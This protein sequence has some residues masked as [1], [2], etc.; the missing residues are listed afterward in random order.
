MRPLLTRLHALLS[1]HKFSSLSTGII[2][3]MCAGLLLPA[4][5]GGLVLTGLRQEQIDKEAQSHI[6]DRVQLLANSLVE[7]VWNVDTRGARTIADA[8]QIAVA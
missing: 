1:G 5:I 8:A 2:I 6:D 4:L 3:A 7:P